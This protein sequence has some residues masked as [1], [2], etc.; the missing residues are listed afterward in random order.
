MNFSFTTLLEYFGISESLIRTLNSIAK[1]LPTIT[2]HS[3]SVCKTES[4]CSVERAG[5][6][7]GLGDGID[8]QQTAK[9]TQSRNNTVDSKPTLR[10]W[11][12]FLS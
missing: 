11:L 12:I 1:K 7:D 2:K 3:D 8:T 10:D 5:F 6:C 4:E 9:A